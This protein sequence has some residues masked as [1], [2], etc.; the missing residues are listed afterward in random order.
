MVAG[1]LTPGSLAL[2][3]MLLIILP[4]PKTV[5]RNDYS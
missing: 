3:S 1:N 2:E 5:W 4:W